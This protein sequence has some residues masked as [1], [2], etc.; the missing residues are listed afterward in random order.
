TL[1]WLAK[2]RGQ[3]RE[4]GHRVSPGFLEPAEASGYA[5]ADRFLWSVRCHLHYLTGRP[6]ERLSPDLQ[7]KVARR[8][9]RHERAAGGSTA[10]L[11]HEYR[12]AAGQVE[13][14]CARVCRQ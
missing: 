11:M 14:L 1:L 5:R 8:M 9:Q 2:I 13:L 6:E 12:Q 3:V 4:V 10:A 7:L